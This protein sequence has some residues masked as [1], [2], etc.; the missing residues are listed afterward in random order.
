MKVEKIFN[1]TEKEYENPELFDERVAKYLVK[2]Y[3]CKHEDAIYS[4]SNAVKFDWA[5]C[6]REGKNGVGIQSSYDRTK[7]YVGI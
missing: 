6:P 5:I 1:M 3:G 4:I 7:L 2:K